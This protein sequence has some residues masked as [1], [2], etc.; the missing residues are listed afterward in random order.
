MRPS[1][2]FAVAPARPL[3]NRL[4]PVPSLARALLGPAAAGLLAAACAT[5]QGAHDYQSNAGAARADVAVATPPRVEIEAD[6]LPAQ[7][8]PRLGRRT[9]PD[10]PTEPFS[11]NY[12]PP[13]APGEVREPQAD[14]PALRRAGGWETG[15][16]PA[17]PREVAVM[18]PRRLTPAEADALIARA[19]I[20]HER[21]YP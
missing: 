18:E 3:P 19:I 20:A 13:P 2:P 12:G 8:P 11:R 9:G 14:V 21:R 4:R 16:R 5:S 6:G 10:D 15:P 17:G 1:I 7:T